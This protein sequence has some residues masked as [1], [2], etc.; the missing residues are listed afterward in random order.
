[1]T[2]TGLE[3]VAWK[4]WRVLRSVDIG[5]NCV[6]MSG[7]SALVLLLRMRIMNYL[8]DGNAYTVAGCLCVRCAVALLIG[9]RRNNGDRSMHWYRRCVPHLGPSSSVAYISSIRCCNNNWS[10]QIQKR[11]FLQGLLGFNWFFLP[12]RNKLGGAV[13]TVLISCS[14]ATRSNLSIAI[15]CEVA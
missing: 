4:L 7:F 13:V 2:Y 14:E 5:V 3:G 11:D 10:M 9:M 15:S 8:C 6:F 1:M 12:C